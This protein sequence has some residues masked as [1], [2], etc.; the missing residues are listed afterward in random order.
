MAGDLSGLARNFHRARACPAI[1]PLAGPNA[2]LGVLLFSGVPMVLRSVL[3]DKSTGAPRPGW[4]GAGRAPYQPLPM[5][6][7]PSSRGSGQLGR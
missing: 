3:V 5:S 1:R 4:I 6:P 7:S 2:A